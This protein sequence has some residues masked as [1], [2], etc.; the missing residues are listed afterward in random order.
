MNVCVC[1]QQNLIG[2]RKK[3]SVEFVTWW[4]NESTPFNRSGGQRV[5][6]ERKRKREKHTD[7]VLKKNRWTWLQLAWV[8]AKLL[9]ELMKR[10]NAFDHATGYGRLPREDVWKVDN[11]KNWKDNQGN[12]QIRKINKQTTIQPIKIKVI[13]SG[14][15]VLFC[16]WSV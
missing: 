16:Q 5:N 10:T 1:G 8:K 4:Q 9:A 2:K 15:C 6:K 3:R 12:T 13:C 7:C 14:V 11:I